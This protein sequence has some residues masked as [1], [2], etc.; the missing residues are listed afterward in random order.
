M[1][2][3]V[4]TIPADDA[5][6]YLH[7]MQSAV[8]V[9]RHFDLLMWLQG[10][11]QHYLP[12]EIMVAAWGDFHLGLVYHDIV[13][14]LPGVRTEHASSSALNPLLKGLFERWVAFGKKPYSLDSGESGFLIEDGGIKCALG[15]ALKEMRSSIVHG[16]SDE[17]GRHDCLYVIFSSQPALQSPS[18]KGALEVLLPY[19]DTALRQVAHLPRQQRNGNGNGTH[20]EPP[21][22]SGEEVDELGL[23]SR[24]REIMDWVRQGKTNQEIAAI[25]DISSFTVKNHLQRIFKKLSVYNRTQAVAR[26]EKLETHGRA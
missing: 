6:R 18:S 23:S 21:A 14:A 12:H 22:A 15:G 1:A 16:I 25:L 3:A 20:S 9:R 4:S 5:S 2:F 19:I 11:M 13:S 8:R 10:D 26:F 24:E 17:R 7:L